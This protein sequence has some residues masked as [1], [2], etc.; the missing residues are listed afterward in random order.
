[1]ID[2][3]PM[4]VTVKRSGAASPND[5][6]VVKISG[7]VGLDSVMGPQGAHTGVDGDTALD[8]ALTK[9]VP[10]SP[11]LV[12]VDLT[13]VT[14]LS[15]LGMGALLRFKHRLAENQSDVRLAGSDQMVT[16]LRRCRLEQVFSLFPTLAA[17]KKG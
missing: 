5:A 13:E 15:S 9:A 16:L 14:Y 4:T 17:A 7:E 12:I 10:A 6:L 3:P 2:K 11:P 1:M 8:A